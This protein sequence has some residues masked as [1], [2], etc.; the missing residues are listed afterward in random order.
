MEREGREGKRTYF[1]RF[2]LALKSPEVGAPPH[3]VVMQAVIFPDTKHRVTTEL[4]SRLDKKEACAEL[5]R[6][7]RNMVTIPRKNRRI[8]PPQTGELPE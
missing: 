1:T 8:E 3:W 7:R 6:I 2:Y 4:C 5:I